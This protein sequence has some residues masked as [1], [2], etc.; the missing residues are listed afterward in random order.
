VP[1]RITLVALWAVFAVASVSVGFAALGLVSDPFTDVGTT[2]DASSLAG[3]AE[4]AVTESDAAAG[5]HE[6]GTAAPSTPSSTST[7]TPSTPTPKAATPTKTH[8]GPVATRTAD[9]TKSSRTGSS[10]PSLVKGG[11]PTEGGY[12]SGTCK[13][14]LVSVGAA[15]A[16]YWQMDSIT[17]GWA[18]TARVRLEPANDAHGE[19]VVVT[20]T[21]QGGSPVF[22]VDTNDGGD[23]G[24]DDG[25]GDSGGSGSGGSD[26]GGGGDSSDSGGG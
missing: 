24:G 8:S 6:T 13:G 22:H 23:G 10:S 7:S 15:P 5:D 25:G 19:R 17:P 2:A 14:A 26:H 3:P 11:V 16:V 12:V 1:R 9:P 4:A 21:C 18:H 20:A